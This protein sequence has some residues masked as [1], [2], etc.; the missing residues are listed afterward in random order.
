MSQGGYD[1]KDGAAP[2]GAG[3][4]DLDNLSGEQIEAVVEA[5]RRSFDED[6]LDMLLV[7]SLNMKL[8]DLAE[9]GPWPVRVFK[10]VEESQKQGF[11]R[12]LI[13][14]IEAERP[15]AERIRGLR[16]QIG[17]LQ[18]PTVGGAAKTAA[19]RQSTNRE[20]AAPK[21]EG[22]P[23]A[24]RLSGPQNWPRRTRL[25]LYC[26]VVAVCSSLILYLI[27]YWQRQA[28]A[29]NAAAQKGDILAWDEYLALAPAS[30]YAKEA[31]TEKAKLIS[32]KQAESETAFAMT[33]ETGTVDAW[34]SFLTA[35]QSYS[36]YISSDHLAFAERM[37]NECGGVDVSGPSGGLTAG[38]DPAKN[39]LARRAVLKAKSGDNAGAIKDIVACQCSDVPVRKESLKP[40]ESQRMI[41]W[42]RIQPS[43]SD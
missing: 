2:A 8:A 32:L 35:Y 41:C 10:V 20:A 22:Q 6:Q 39:M 36:N 25:I 12:Q 15:K 1:P 4:S 29:F 38:A 3:A 30:Y 33:R 40:E 18:K 21:A 5:I 27:V 37:I 9:P 19:D 7:Q 26:F 43:A 16:V 28:D 11:G 13:E 23:V 42:L 34:L 24:A 17:Q 31:K 14:A